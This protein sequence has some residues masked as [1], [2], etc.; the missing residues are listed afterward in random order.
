MEALTTAPLYRNHLRPDCYTLST[1]VR[2]SSHP[3]EI[4]ELLT[5]NPAAVTPPVLRCAIE[6]LG[7]LGDPSAAL[8]LFLQQ[9]RYKQTSND[10]NSDSLSVGRKTGDAIITALLSCP[11]QRL[12]LT[13]A[14][15]DLCGKLSADV[16]TDLLF[17]GQSDESKYCIRCSSKGYTLLFTHIQRSLR[18]LFEP[19]SFS[20]ENPDYAE[21]NSYSQ[22]L[23]LAA[24]ANL[25]NTRNRL[26][27]YMKGEIIAEKSSTEWNSTEH[28][29]RNVADDENP[30]VE[31][32]SR[33]VDAL[34]R[35]V[36]D[37]LLH[38]CFHTVFVI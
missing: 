36:V 25:R 6:S 13:A 8:M 4:V 18:R 37:C 38:K 9:R 19:V 11:S 26:F 12:N 31:L 7:N 32:N 1:L 30:S 23:R 27:E 35:F 24:A 15:G 28:Q 10:S 5:Q 14:F 16:A 2:I 20:S 3:E 29:E 21:E 33:L 17:D 34:V 22:R